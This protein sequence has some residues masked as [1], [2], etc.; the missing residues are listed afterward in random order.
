MRWDG[1][2]VGVV[3]EVVKTGWFVVCFRFRF[4][5]CDCG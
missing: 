5:D 2:V 3:R 4:R 1:E